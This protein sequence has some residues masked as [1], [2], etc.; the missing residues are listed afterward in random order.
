MS[1]EQHQIEKFKLNEWF[2]EDY[3]DKIIKIRFKDRIE[4]KLNGEYHNIFDAA[5]L[6]FKN[7]DI[8]Q[9]YINGKHFKDKIEWQAEALKLARRSKIRN[10][11][12]ED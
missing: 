5:I 7:S 1:L 2:F 8:N 12:K 6:Y 3:Q 4:S 11:F 10:I 9:Y